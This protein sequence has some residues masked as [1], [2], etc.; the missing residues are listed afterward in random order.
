MVCV[1]LSEKH[2]H[3]WH[4]VTRK[5][6]GATGVQAKFRG[7]SCPPWHPLAP[8][9][10]RDMCHS[11]VPTGLFVAIA[12]LQ[13]VNPLL[14]KSVLSLSGILSLNSYFI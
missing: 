8:T 6:L 10:F 11:F 2:P 9:L 3:Q 5:I 13:M 1:G 4:D 7:G 14:Q 12:A